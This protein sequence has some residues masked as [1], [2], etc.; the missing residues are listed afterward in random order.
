MQGGKGGA[1]EESWSE[2]ELLKG[3]GWGALGAERLSQG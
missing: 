2:I 3:R 1:E